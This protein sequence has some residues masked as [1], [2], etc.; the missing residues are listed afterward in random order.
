MCAG[1]MRSVSGNRSFCR[2]DYTD[3]FCGSPDY[4]VGDDE[5]GHGNL[6]AYL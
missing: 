6:H 4:L 1:A 2:K 3:L 5:V